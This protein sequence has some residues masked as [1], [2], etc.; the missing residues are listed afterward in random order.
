MENHPKYQFI[1]MIAGIF[2]ILGFINLVSIVYNTKRTEHLTFTWIFLILTAQSLLVIYGIL[3]KAY[4]IYLPSSIVCSGI[5]YILYVKL[6]Y[7]MA[8]KVETELKIKNIL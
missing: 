6:N 4:G 5:L 3:N 2:T 7:E 8:Y 1:A